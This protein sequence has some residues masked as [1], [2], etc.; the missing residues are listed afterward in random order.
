MSMSDLQVG[1]VEAQAIRERFAI[2]IRLASEADL[3]D[4]AALR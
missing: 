3:Q 4:V 2:L 1:A